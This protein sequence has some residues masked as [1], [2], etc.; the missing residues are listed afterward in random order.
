[1]PVGQEVKEIQQI[2]WWRTRVEPLG[3]H[4]S[5]QSS[6]VKGLQSA[7]MVALLV[8][9]VWTLDR[10]LGTWRKETQTLA[11]IFLNKI[12]KN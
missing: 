2:D 4:T 6:K 11:N 10:S 9:R 3:L 5:A 12:L 7:Y 8:P 1:M